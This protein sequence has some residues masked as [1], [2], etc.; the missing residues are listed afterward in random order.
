MKGVYQHC[1]EKHLHRYVAEFDFRYNHREA[2]GVDDDARTVAAVLEAKASGD[3]ST[4]SLK[5]ISSIGPRGSCAGG[6]SGRVDR[7]PNRQRLVVD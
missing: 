5:R 7:T 2:L 6:R 1:D 3:L 4:A